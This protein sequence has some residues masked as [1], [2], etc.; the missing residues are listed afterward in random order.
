MNNPYQVTSVEK[1][2]HFRFNFDI[3]YNYFKEDYLKNSRLYSE[4]NR[5][6]EINENLFY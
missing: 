6:Y 1:Y 2:N 5:I 3:E 4:L